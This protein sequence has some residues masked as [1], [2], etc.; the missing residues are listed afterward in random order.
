MKKKYGNQKAI[1][2]FETSS[3]GR[4]VSSGK[5]V[6]EQLSFHKSLLRKNDL[7]RVLSTL[8]KSG[9]MVKGSRAGI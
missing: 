2:C 3:P 7:D 6:V 4:A 5:H 9:G 1:S 8:R